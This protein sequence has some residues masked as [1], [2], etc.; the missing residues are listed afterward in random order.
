MNIRNKDN[1]DLR[2]SNIQK[3]QAWLSER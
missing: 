2:E 1:A 3:E